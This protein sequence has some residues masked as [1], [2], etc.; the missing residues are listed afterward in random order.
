MQE[1]SE[2]LLECFEMLPITEGLLKTTESAQSQGLR[3]ND[4]R[5]ILKA[6]K[7]G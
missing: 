1:I 7:I 2:N 6:V 3:L 5:V 4:W